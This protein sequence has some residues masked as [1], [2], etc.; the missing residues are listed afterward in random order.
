[1]WLILLFATFYS[2][3][4]SPPWLKF[5]TKLSEPFFESC[6]NSIPQNLKERDLAQSLVCGKKVTDEKKKKQLIDNG[7]I[8]SFVVSGSHLLALYFLLALLK[9]SRILQFVFILAYTLLTHFQAPAVRALVQ[10]LIGHRLRSRALNL[11]S[12]Q[13]ILLSGILCL[14][15]FPQWSSSYSFFLSWGCSL[16]LCLSSE[17]TNNPIRRGVLT[18]LFLSPFLFGLGNPHPVSILL[19]LTAAPLI[20]F[21]L[22][23][24][25]TLTIFIP[26]TGSA[27]DFLICV[28]FK[29][30]EF[31]PAQKSPA[32]SNFKMSLSLWGLLLS[33]HAMTR[34]VIW[35]QRRS[36][37]LWF[38]NKGSTSK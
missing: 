32:L 18:Y 24:I 25:A 3:L 37:S 8:H 13:K 23:P 22:L 21:I 26:G 16:A 38:H 2:S 19:N 30:L 27:F 17:L 31:L 7:L 10:L 29:I 36:R 4:D 6:L 5:C 34:F 11:S 12:D 14:A 1:M 33:C 15:L 20:H 28:F 35:Y 9:L